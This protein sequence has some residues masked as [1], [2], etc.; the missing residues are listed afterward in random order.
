M[1]V[2]GFYYRRGFTLIELLVVI[3]IIAITAAILF[4]V[5]AQAK[6]SAKQQVCI[7]NMKQIG[8]AMMLYL[9]D[10]DDTWP[11]AVFIS[12]LQG[13]ARQQMWIGYDNNNYPLNGGFYGRVHFPR[14]NRPRPGALDPYIQNE[15]IKRCPLM[16]DSWQMAYAT[17][18]FNPAYGSAYYSRN[19]AARN[20]EYGPMVRNCV[21]IGGAFDCYGLQNSMVHE[22][23][24]TL[25]MW[26]HEARVPMCN[27]LQ[28]DD[29]FDRP[30]NSNYLRQHFHFLHRG[31]ANALW[32]DS[33]A[34]RL[35]YDQLKRPMFSSRKDIYPET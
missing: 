22:P 32:A 13:F 21:L 18:F 30:P 34:K 7:S 28:P 14:Q 4:P 35:V 11:S 8:T 23:A 17:N 33:H 27:F 9:G 15:A 29:W 10:H 19:P 31:A 24:F 16:P 6:I 25:V 26:E 20:N 5:F 12:P 2:S 1:F 3:T